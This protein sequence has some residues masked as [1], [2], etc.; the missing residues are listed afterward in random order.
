MMLFQHVER[1]QMDNPWKL[2]SP[3]NANSLW[4]A[5]MVLGL[6]MASAGRGGMRNP[7]S[8]DSTV[9]HADFLRQDGVGHFLREELISRRIW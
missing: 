8:V 1:L 6:L 9:T 3:L 4:M 7:S 2:S 5:Q